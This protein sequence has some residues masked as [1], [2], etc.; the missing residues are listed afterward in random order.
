VAPDVVNFVAKQKA[1][2]FCLDAATRNRYLIR[3]LIAFGLGM[4]VIRSRVSITD[5]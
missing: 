1:I 3:L 2:G 5:R 4:V